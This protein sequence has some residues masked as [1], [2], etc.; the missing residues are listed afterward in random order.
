MEEKGGGYLHK[1]NCTF[2]LSTRAT[3]SIS[4]NNCNCQANVVEGQAREVSN[5]VVLFSEKSTPTEEDYKNLW[6]ASVV[7]WVKGTIGDK[8]GFVSFATY[9]GSKEEVLQRA[10][11]AREEKAK[12]SQ[13]LISDFD[14]FLFEIRQRTKPVEVEM[15]DI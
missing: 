5:E 1:W 4:E 3:S 7:K 10:M 8:Y 2:V 15:L 6:S 11:R 12:N 9:I 14:I 13:A